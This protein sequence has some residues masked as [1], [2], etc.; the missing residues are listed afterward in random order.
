MDKLGINLGFFLFQL[1]NFGILFF[2]LARFVWP[3]VLDMLDERA[4]RIAKGLEDARAAQ[5][6]REDAQRER[7]KLLSQARTEGQKYI[8]EARQRGAEQVQLMLREASRQADEHRAQSRIQAEEDRNRVLADTREQIVSL[9]MA[10]AEQ[11]VG[12][13]LDEE[14]QRA[15]IKRFFTDVP[16]AAKGLG[17]RIE[18]VSALPLTDDEQAAIKTISGTDEITFKVNPDILGGLI[19]RSGDKVVDG[20]VRGDLTALSVRIH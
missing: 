6:A 16:A 9:A 18:V 4:E 7:D 3:R 11:L 12:E 15:I 14:R 13:V 20:S 10:A 2:V 19:L 8:D 17:K 1:F 5:E